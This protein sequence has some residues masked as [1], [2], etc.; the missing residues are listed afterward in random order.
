MKQ[1]FFVF[2]I[3]LCPFGVAQAGPGNMDSV[4]NVITG[5]WRADFYAGGFAGLPPTPVTSDE[6]V[7]FSRDAQDSVNQTFSYRIYQNGLATDSG[8]ASLRMNAGGFY[9]G[10]FLPDIF[11]SGYDSI[12]FELFSD[13]LIFTHGFPDEFVYGYVRDSCAEVAPPDTGFE[14]IDSVIQTLYGC[15]KWD[16]Y[17]GGFAGIP[18]TQ[19]TSNVRMEFSQDAQDSMNHTLSC[20][21]YENSV[22]K[23]S[24]RC[25]IDDTSALP[26][27]TLSCP[28]FDSIGIIGSPP[29]YFNFE[30][31]TLLFP[32]EQFVDGFVYAFLQNCDTVNSVQPLRN[33]D[34]KI[35]PVPASQQI[36]IELSDAELSGYGIYDA[37][38][39]KLFHARCEKLRE[40]TFSASNYPPGIY[41]LHL[42][43]NRG[44]LYRKILIGK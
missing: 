5:C 34:V 37:V 27:F 36:Q 35:Y 2:I 24:G 43:T 31:D 16:H 15:W 32:Q 33:E 7:R 12:Y 10:T 41:F 40:L 14:T 23:F 6:G 18:P 21:S 25:A 17:F 26:F 42:E 9:D 20:A 1:H 8:R 38:G 44:L 19:A 28:I 29:L 4:L 30:N 39:Q 3:F 13:T 22:L 11:P